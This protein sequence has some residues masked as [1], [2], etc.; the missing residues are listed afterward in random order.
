MEDDVSE[1]L[2]PEEGERQGPEGGDDVTEESGESIVELI[3]RVREELRKLASGGENKEKDKE[4]REGQ[5]DMVVHE[6]GKINVEQVRA[7]CMEKLKR[8]RGL[9]KQYA[10]SQ[11]STLEPSIHSQF[12]RLLERKRLAES[13]LSSVKSSSL[14]TFLR[15]TSLLSCLSSSSSSSCLSSSFDDSG[16]N[17]K[18]KDSIAS[19]LCLDNLSV[20]E[21]QRLLILHRLSPFAESLKLEQSME[22]ESSTWMM[23]ERNFLLEV[24]FSPDEKLVDSV[25][26]AA[27][28]TANHDTDSIVVPSLTRLLQSSSIFG[29]DHAFEDRVVEFIH[30]D[31]LMRRNP[32]LPLLS[33]WN[34]ISSQSIPRLASSF[35]HAPID[36]SSEF[37]LSFVYHTSASLSF[38]ARLSL[39]IGPSH[40][41]SSP[42]SSSPFH[43]LSLSPISVSPSS[44]MP[45]CDISSAG[46]RFNIVLSP[47]ILTSFSLL[48]RLPS[49]T[50]LN[51]LA[52][53]I[54]DHS[55]KVDSLSTLSSLLRSNR[56]P[57]VPILSL[58]LVHH[59]HEN[60][61]QHSS[62]DLP[63]YIHRIP[64]LDIDSLYLIVPF[65]QQQI[66]WNQ[67][68]SSFFSS[69]SFSTLPSFELI[70][71]EL[72]AH[73]PSLFSLTLPHPRSSSLLVHLKIFVHPGGARSGQ[74]DP[75]TS[76]TIPNSLFSQLVEHCLSLP[77]VVH[78]I[79]SL[80]S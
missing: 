50:P 28:V 66:V 75:L 41:D 29:S 6:Y 45:L 25:K 59:Y 46:I 22:H 60:T 4:R 68:Y 5:R 3:E 49:S 36:S 65:L 42:P 70:N 48:R 35:S 32:A 21:W 62:S 47:P 58:N 20:A 72:L 30:F 52:S 31:H 40:T 73:S 37:S 17:Q 54:F 9:L 15:R 74:S 77:L 63:L 10:R 24:C 14:P 12:L 80:L 57:L 33:F 8:I 67:L 23:F 53:T 34:Q 69:S 61:Q 51:F 7:V 64:F 55:T 2:L 78:H 39:E 18:T 11:A 43:S 13:L 19:R 56:R 71:I 26:I 27:N 16:S 44:S 1:W 79:I 38:S 76:E